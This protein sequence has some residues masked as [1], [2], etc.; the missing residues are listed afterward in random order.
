[1]HMHLKCLAHETAIQFYKL[2]HFYQVY[3]T[4]ILSDPDGTV[5]VSLYYLK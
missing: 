3:F 1:M 2:Y 5:K 4:A